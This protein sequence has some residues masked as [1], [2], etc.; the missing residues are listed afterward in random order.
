MWFFFFPLCN[1]LQKRS[2]NHLKLVSPVPLVFCAF[3]TVHES[4]DFVLSAQGLPEVYRESRS[5]KPCTL[6]AFST[7]NNHPDS[8]ISAFMVFLENLHLATLVS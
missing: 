6:L 4:F 7:L 2:I 8:A 3:G 5:F 1:Q